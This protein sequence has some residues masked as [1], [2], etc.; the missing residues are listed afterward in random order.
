MGETMVS[1]WALT[2][3]WMMAAYLESALRSTLVAR[4][5]KRER[6]VSASSLA[7]VVMPSS[8]N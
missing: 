3:V 1:P 7:A 4:C 8:I 6:S 2:P 5:S